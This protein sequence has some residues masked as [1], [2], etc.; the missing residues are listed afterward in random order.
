[1]MMKK[2]SVFAGFA[3]CLA[4]VF[5]AGASQVAGNQPGM[6]FEE[7]V[8]KVA[9]YEVGESRAAVTALNQ[10]IVAAASSRARAGE[11]ERALIKALEGKA[12]LEGKDQFCRHLSLIGSAASVPVLSKMLGNAE[13]ADMARYAIE[14]IPGA[15]VDRALRAE[16][17]PNRVRILHP[18]R[19]GVVEVGGPV[20]DRRVHA[21]RLT[22]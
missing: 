9:A 18:G 5:S 15:E 6:S 2:T 12:T 19:V 11:M 8:T 14:R 17:V 4:L 16:L 20:L 10:Q 13:T 1:M 7:A 3:L 21:H 22:P